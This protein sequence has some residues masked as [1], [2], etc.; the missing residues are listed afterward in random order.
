MAKRTRA[1]KGQKIYNT[2]TEMDV[3]DDEWK[4]L[5]GKSEEDYI[6]KNLMTEED[7]EKLRGE[8]ENS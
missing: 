6:N 4:R 1:F 8:N 2:D 7:K 5:F 3:P